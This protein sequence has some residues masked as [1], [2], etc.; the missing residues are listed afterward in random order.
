[1]TYNVIYIALNKY[2]NDLLSQ[3][4]NHLGTMVEMREKKK[5]RG[6]EKTEEES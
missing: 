6:V 2:R 1:M 3:P 4:S 5:E